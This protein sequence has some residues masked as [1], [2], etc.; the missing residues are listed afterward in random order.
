MKDF[1]DVMGHLEKKEQKLITKSIGKK[2]QE[3]V[4]ARVENL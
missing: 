4:K 1:G 3:L 2:T